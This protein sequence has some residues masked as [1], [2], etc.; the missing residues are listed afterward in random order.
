[1]E[2]KYSSKSFNN[3]FLEIIPFADHLHLSDSSSL[4]N[5]GLNIDD[6]NIDFKFTLDNIF[7]T[8]NNKE[9][10]FIPEVWQ[11]HLNDGEGFKISLER[12]ASYLS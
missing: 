7:K 10:S 4:S 1:M 8:N 11:G 6:G 9:I 12:I 5:E 2:S 3:N